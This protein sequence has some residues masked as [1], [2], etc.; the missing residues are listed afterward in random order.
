MSPTLLPRN[1]TV[2]T[3][4]KTGN[5][6]LYIPSWKYPIIFDQITD[7]TWCF[8]CVMIF[9]NPRKGVPKWNIHQSSKERLY[10]CP[11]PLYCCCQEHP[12]LVVRLRPLY[13]GLH[14]PALHRQ[15]QGHLWC[16]LSA[17]QHL[18]LLQPHPSTLQ[19]H[20]RVDSGL[21][22]LNCIN[23]VDCAISEHNM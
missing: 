11:Y 15:L 3:P 17:E 14:Q 4:G 5:V 1:S 2:W 16:H 8:F 18:H 20:V 7:L 23:C 22:C 21:N 9:Q 12:M 13:H 10:N 19:Q 6:C